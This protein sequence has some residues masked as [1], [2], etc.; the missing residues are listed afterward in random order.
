MKQIA[1]DESNNKVI[2][3]MSTQEYQ[4]LAMLCEAYD[5]GLVDNLSLHLGDFERYL[6]KPYSLEQPID[7]IRH[8]IELYYSANRLKELSDSLEI[9][10]K[11]K[12]PTLAATKAALEHETKARKGAKT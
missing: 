2:V 7:A 6:N 9:F 11:Q 1:R 3:E 10:V 12:A 4:A 5:G 8:F